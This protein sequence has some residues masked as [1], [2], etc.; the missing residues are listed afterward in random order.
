MTAMTIRCAGLTALAISAF[1]ATTAAAPVLS[2]STT[3]ADFA[4]GLTLVAP[5]TIAGQFSR[6]LAY[7]IQP[8]QNSSGGTKLVPS[9]PF[10]T[11]SSSLMGDWHPNP[12]CWGDPTTC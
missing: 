2:S 11:A 9:V 10:S 6:A 8:S 5:P 3:P 7:G 1:A 4:D 12:H